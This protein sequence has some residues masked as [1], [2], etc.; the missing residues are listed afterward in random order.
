MHEMLVTMVRLLVDSPEDV[1]VE[2]A[3]GDG[4]VR[5]VVHV[6]PSDVGRV[7]GR[8]GKVIRSLRVLLRA[9]AA[10]AGDR[11]EIELAADRSMN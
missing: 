3:R 9:A 7:I 2:E 11:V 1:R 8:Q 10:R 5:L 6:A 4:T